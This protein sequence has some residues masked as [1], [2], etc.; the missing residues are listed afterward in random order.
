MLLLN[1]ARCSKL[2]QFAK[3]IMFRNRSL[4]WIFTRQ[5]SVE[6]SGDLLRSFAVR[7]SLKSLSSKR[8]TYCFRSAPVFTWYRNSSR[9]KYKS[10][11]HTNALFRRCVS[12]YVEEPNVVERV[13]F[14]CCCVILVRGF[15]PARTLQEHCKNYTN[16]LCEKPI[17]CTTSA[18]RDRTMAILC[19]S[20]LP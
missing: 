6:R 13:L 19:V 17:Y 2:S 7:D 1:R 10:G 20:H 14:Y 18:T 11:T 5:Y 16:R 15:R 8:H 3:G 9:Y 4:C 12:Q